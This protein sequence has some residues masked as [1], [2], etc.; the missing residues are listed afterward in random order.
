MQILLPNEGTPAPGMTAGAEVL[1]SSTALAAAAGQIGA[2]HPAAPQFASNVITVMFTDMVGSTDLTAAIGDQAMQVLIHRHD[3]IVRQAVAAHGGRE[4][5]HTGDGIMAAFPTSRDGVEAAIEIQRANADANAREQ[6]LPPLLLTIGL[7][8]GEPVRENNDLFG[9]TVQIAARVCGAAKENQIL[10]SGTVRDLARSD[11]LTF[12]HIG[13]KSLKGVAEP[14]P[15]YMARWGGEPAPAGDRLA[16]AGACTQMPAMPP[17]SQGYAMPQGAMPLVVHGMP[18]GSVFGF[19]GG[20]PPQPAQ[21]DIPRDL[22]N[23]L[24][25]AARGPSILRSVF[26]WVASKLI[27]LAIIAGVLSAF[28]LSPM[29]IWT[30]RANVMATL[31]EIDSMEDIGRVAMESLSRIQNG[32]MASLTGNESGTRDQSSGSRT[33]PAGAGSG[34]PQ[35]DPLGGLFGGMGGGLGSAFGGLM[36]Q[37]G[38]GGQPSAQPAPRRAPPEPGTS[39]RVSAVEGQLAR[40]LPLGDMSPQQKTAFTLLAEVGAIA[41]ADLE[42]PVLRADTVRGAQD[43]FGLP[44]TGHVDPALIAALEGFLGNRAAVATPATPN[45]AAPATPVLIVKK[46]ASVADLELGPDGQTALIDA[47][48]K[49]LDA[50]GTIVDW[51]SPAGNATGQALAGETLA[52]PA[53]QGRA[54]IKLHQ[55][56][57]LSAGTPVSGT[58]TACRSGGVWT[59][60]SR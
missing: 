16:E 51:V 8:T 11:R 22:E 24:D 30:A 28:G 3:A 18:P 35:A 57:R 31:G 25:R 48:H 17:A 2:A 53:G 12:I 58:G 21:M 27:I 40:D 52:D 15:I 46:L 60:D 13:T 45:G 29:K 34:D 36:G 39:F 19:P 42:A 20:A 54:C 41:D 38:M 33:N 44:Q 7:H 56:A 32:A 14:V 55:V 47:S 59:V 6:N 43:I 23:R 5:K 10:V 50:P 9:A 26:V 4:I 1:R 49:A 37:F